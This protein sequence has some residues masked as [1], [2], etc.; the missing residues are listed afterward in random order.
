MP[1]PGMPV[2]GMPAPLV[3]VTLT[4]NSTPPGAQVLRSTGELLG[5]TPLV[6]QIQLPA[7]QLGLPQTFTFNLAGYQPTTATGVAVNNSMMISATLMPAGGGIAMPGMGGGPRTISAH[8]SGGGPIFDYHTTT[9][10]ATVNESCIIQS[11]QVRVNGHH[12]YFSDL[13]VSLRGP[14]GQSASLQR[15]RSQNPFRSYSPSNVRGTQA[16]GT[17]TL[18]IRDEVGADSGN[19]AGFSMTISCQ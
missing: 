1:V 7:D 10:R 5:M 18:S 17:W 4:A 6:A 2:P 14:A 8:G 12:S 11:L 9:A 15:R 16:M 13:A 3:A 19:L